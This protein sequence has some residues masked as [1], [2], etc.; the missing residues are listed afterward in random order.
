MLHGGQDDGL[1]ARELAQGHGA[2]VLV[3]EHLV[4]RRAGVGS[5]SDG[6]ELGGIER[7]G[8]FRRRA[9]GKHHH[10]QQRATPVH[11]ALPVSEDAG[12]SASGQPLAASRVMARSMGMRAS[13]GP[14]SERP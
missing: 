5:W 1:A 3:E 6:R 8:R 13:P 11:R 12:A 4:Q 7:R 14:A 2:A 10:R 9:E